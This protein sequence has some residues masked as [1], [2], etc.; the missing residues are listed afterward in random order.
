LNNNIIAPTI[1]NGVTI[2]VMAAI[3]FTALFLIAQAF[4]MVKG[5]QG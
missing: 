4:H 1:V 5:A 3:G 2:T